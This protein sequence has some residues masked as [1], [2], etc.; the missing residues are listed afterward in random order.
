MSVISSIFFIVFL[1]QLYLEMHSV[2]CMILSQA[3]DL[4]VS[5]V[6]YLVKVLLIL[7]CPFSYWQLFYVNY[8]FFVLVKLDYPL[9]LEFP[10]INFVYVA[11]VSF[12]PRPQLCELFIILKSFP[13]HL[14]NFPWIE[15][16]YECAPP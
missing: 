12:I 5:F 2:F 6:H 7:F 15:I 11:H 10:S 8:S 3:Y 14:R 9:Y 13:N 4:A 1:V 16:R